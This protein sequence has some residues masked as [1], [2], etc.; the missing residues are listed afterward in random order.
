MGCATA[1][2]E[3]TTRHEIGEDNT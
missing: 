3:E 1:K 2:E